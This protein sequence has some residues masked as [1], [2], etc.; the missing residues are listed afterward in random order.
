MLVSLGCWLL[1]FS[2]L[3]TNALQIFIIKMEGEYGEHFDFCYNQK[4]EGEEE[5]ITSDMESP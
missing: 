4:E 2:L 3:L 5:N 1:L